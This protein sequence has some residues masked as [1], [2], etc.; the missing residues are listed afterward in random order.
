MS[1]PAS[2]T[3]TASRL[4]INLSW[5]NDWGDQQM[6]FVDVMRNARGF[7][8]TDS[9]WDPTNHPV[10]VGADGWPTTDFGVMFL[11]APGD[12]AGRSLGAT[13]PSMF[14]TY[15]LSFT[16]QATVTGP[17]CTVQNLQYNKAT[18]T[19]T[20][21]VVLAS[22]SNSLSLVFTN[23][24][25]AV[26]NIHLLRPGYPVGT[27]QVF[28]DAFLN[29]LQ[30]FSTLRFM[31]F[32]QTNDNPVTS[33]AGRTLPTNPV[34]SGPGGVAWE[35]VIQLANA[36]GK[37]VW[38]NIPEGVDLADT[39]QG[40][41]VIQLAKLLKANL[42]PGIHVYVEYSNE[43][44][45]GLFQ[46]STDNQNAAVSEVQS[47]ADKNLNYD[48]VN[49]EYYWALRRD[50]HQTVRISQLFS[51]VYGATAMGSVIRPV[52]ASQY[53]QPYL[54]E[55]SLAYINANFGAPKQYLYGIASAP[56][57]SASNF[58]SVDG[59]I[60]SLKSNIKEI[61]AGFS[62]KSY[63]GGVD[64]SVTSYKPIADYYGLKN[65]A[66][67][68]GPDFGYDNASNAIAEKALSDPRLNRLVQQELADWYGKN[69]DLLMYYELASGPGNYY[70]A[71]E[72]MALATPKS[73]ALS[74]VSSTPL[75][76]YTSGAGAVTALS[77]TPA[78]ADLGTG[79]TVTLQV[80]LSQPVWI[81]GTPTL[82][83]ND[84]GKASYAGGSGTRVLTFKHTI[85]AGQN[86][87]DL[88]VTA[89]GLPS[90][91]TVTDA[92]GSTASLAKAVGAI[93]GH[94][95][96]DTAR[97]RI[98]IATGTGQTVDAS[99]GNDVVT[100]ADGNATLVFKGSNNVAFLGDGKG[101][102]TATVNDGSTGLTAY[103]LDTG[104]YTFTG[105][106]T[107]TGAVVDLL[108]GLGGYTTAAEV[109]A[110]L[111]SDGSGGTNLPLGGSGMIHF[112]G[113]EPAK[114][115]A[116]NFRIG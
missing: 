34:Q 31:D 21:D 102:L 17:D 103:V 27:T 97:T 52:L 32:L 73:Q 108:G 91:A 72:D 33:W 19:S 39:S 114:L 24:K 79:A 71:Y 13:V 89:T 95:I 10:P 35:Y 5:V 61:D 38:I 9:Y 87:S 54:I 90:G 111:R 65:L 28:T 92:G 41:Y 30:P 16:G 14:G 3:N 58:Q 115:G 63:A 4:G 66:Y 68:G 112:T 74:T 53:V 57:V 70:G 77:A 106:A 81:T 51:Q 78:N 26:K 98:T 85:A 100:L 55:D 25:A 11:T 42:L 7:A 18:N 40:N 45:N 46:Q 113:I 83:L 93:P 64:Y 36:T 86:A 109:V 2:S 50:A 116:A 104:T 44:W 80:T 43:L 67:E 96:V 23:T 76:G 110:A 59:V 94:M 62:G 48:K 22:T 82:T 37:D 29:A 47:G 6:T 15:H 69:N 75:S 12:P 20:A 88:A 84:G 101:T 107:D 1:T 56:Y 105:L 60:S 99:S 49:N 8:T